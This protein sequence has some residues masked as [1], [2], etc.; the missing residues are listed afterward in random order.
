MSKVI[1]HEVAIG[2]LDRAVAAGRVHHAYLLTGPARVG[3]STVARWL[4]SRLNC[5]SALA[6]CGSCRDCQLIRAGAHPDVRALQSAAD[7][8]P[9]LGLALD[10]PPRSSRAAE[11]VIS[12]DQIRALQH[13]AALAPHQGGW[14]VYL[15]VGAENL[16]LDGANCL[17]KTLEEPPVQVVLVLTAIDPLDLPATVVSRCQTIRLGTVPL[18]TLTSGLVTEAGADPDQAELLARLSGGRPGWAIEA[19]ANP[20]LLAERN[21]AL[22]A[23]RQALGRSFRERLTLAERLAND[24][25]KDPARVL[26]VL[27]LWQLYWWDIHLAQQG[28]PDLLTNVDRREAIEALARGL[29]PAAVS[30]AVQR[31]GLAAQRLAQNVN[32][33][34]ALEAL[35]VRS[36]SAG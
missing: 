10:P 2:L 33:R 9:P 16:S 36:P 30:A 4:A 11:R 26:R 25:T 22:E 32:P 1:G 24:F 21:D 15:I 12:I 18:A 20:A 29:D 28:C 6:P 13:D 23:L 35:L 34:L 19:L 3:K 14:K 7:R 8:D 17:L 31:I 27:S 5:R